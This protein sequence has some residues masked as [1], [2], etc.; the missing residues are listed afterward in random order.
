MTPTATANTT[1]PFRRA[2]FAS[3]PEMLDY[4]ARGQTVSISSIHEDG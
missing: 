1:L 3:V 2:G 4:A